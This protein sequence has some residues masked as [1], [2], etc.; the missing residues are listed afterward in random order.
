LT[1]AFTLAA[2]TVSDWGKL[3]FKVFP[4][5]VQVPNAPSF[6]PVTIQSGA[7]V[8]MVVISFLSKFTVKATVSSARLCLRVGSYSTA[9]QHL[10]IC[11]VMKE[12]KGIV[13]RGWQHYAQLAR[14]AVKIPFKTA[15]ALKSA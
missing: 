2:R 4:H 15:S 3:I 5:R 1:N 13:R 11:S 12:Q 10:H 6:P 8:F 9:H 7:F 14:P